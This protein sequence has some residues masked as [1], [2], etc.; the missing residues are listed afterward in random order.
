MNLG[1]VILGRVLCGVSCLGLNNILLNIMCTTQIY[2]N[3]IKDQ[4]TS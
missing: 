2:K 1:R 3:D 4:I